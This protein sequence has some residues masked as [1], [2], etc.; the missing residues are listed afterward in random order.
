LFR[1]ESNLYFGSFEKSRGR[2]F[3]NMLI[4]SPLTHCGLVI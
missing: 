1:N 2:T 4:D 3:E